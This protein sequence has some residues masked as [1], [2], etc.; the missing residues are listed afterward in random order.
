MN[1]IPN[2]DNIQNTRSHAK[3]MQHGASKSLWQTNASARPPGGKN[4]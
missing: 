4:A 2:Q 1:R 3:Q